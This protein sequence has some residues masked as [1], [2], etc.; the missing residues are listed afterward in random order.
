MKQTEAILDY[1]ESKGPITALTALSE[2]GCLRLS[3]RIK[4][5]RDSGIEV[6]DRF[7][8]TVNSSGEKKTFKEYWVDGKKGE[9]A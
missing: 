4:E 6:K 8:T 2:C 5:L 7:V 3:A 9:N 1:M